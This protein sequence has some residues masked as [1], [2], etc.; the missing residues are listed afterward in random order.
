ML[1]NV[2]GI[3]SY[4]LLL[5]FFV[6]LSPQKLLGAVLENNGESRVKPRYA[7]LSAG[8][9]LGSYVFLSIGC[10]VDGNSQRRR[11]I[12]SQSQKEKEFARIK[13]EQESDEQARKQ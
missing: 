10:K 5:L 11:N 13:E 7:T 9:P 6:I 4:V 3:Q 2:I 1:I 8:G 12:N